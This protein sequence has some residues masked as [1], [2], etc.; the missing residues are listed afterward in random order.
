MWRRRLGRTGAVPGRGGRTHG[1][2]LPLRLLPSCRLP[3]APAKDD[4][5]S[6]M[7]AGFVRKTAAILVL[8]HSRLVASLARSLCKPNQP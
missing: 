7:C 4:R 8:L 2:R 6:D 1:H 5:Q 3:Y